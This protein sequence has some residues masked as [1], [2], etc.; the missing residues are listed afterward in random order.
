MVVGEQPNVTEAN[1]TVY[2]DE[3]TEGKNFS[4]FVSQL[5]ANTKYYFK[6][7]YTDSPQNNEWTKELVL[8]GIIKD[9]THQVENMKTVPLSNGFMFF[10]GTY[11][12]FDAYTSF[13]TYNATTKQYA[14]FSP[15]GID[16]YINSHSLGCYGF[17]MN[18]CPYVAMYAGNCYDKGVHIYKF[19]EG[20]K[21]FSLETSNPKRFGAGNVVNFT[22]GSQAYIGG[23]YYIPLFSNFKTEYTKD[24]WK[25][26]FVTKEWRQLKDLP[27]SEFV[28]S[29]SFKNRIY[30]IARGSDNLYEYNV[31]SDTWNLI[32]KLPFKT[33]V[34]MPFSDALYLFTSH[35]EAE[36]YV[37]KVW[38]A[39]GL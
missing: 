26:D 21:T 3:K 12:G 8:D 38:K 22:I 14:E 27:E 31:S 36:W 39:V 34:A 4:F 10:K 13:Y 29:F 35:E 37:N 15:S 28:A 7:F 16:D 5:Y 11:F 9:R 33:V 32:E 20:S 17:L 6:V 19:D 24:F 30:A 23:G 1:G 2:S 18:K 25:Y